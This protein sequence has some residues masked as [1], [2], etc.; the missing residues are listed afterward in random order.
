MRLLN[1]IRA[2]QVSGTTFLC[3]ETRA[4]V[5]AHL[6]ADRHRPKLQGDGVRGLHACRRQKHEL[7]RIPA[8]DCLRTT[9]KE[10]IR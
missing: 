10:L 7:P 8:A 5:A 4:Q 1:E 3:I 2:K 9:R 6:G